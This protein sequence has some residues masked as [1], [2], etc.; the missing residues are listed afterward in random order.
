MHLL[1]ERLMETENQMTRIL[2]AMEAVQHHVGQ[3]AE[4]Y[5]EAQAKAGLKAEASHLQQ[6]TKKRTVKK[7]CTGIISLESIP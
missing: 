3:T 7:V 2:R 5:E 4:E 1:K 6:H